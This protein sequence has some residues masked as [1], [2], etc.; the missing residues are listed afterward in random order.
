MKTYN[1]LICILL[2]VQLSA[3]IDCGNGINDFSD[4]ITVSYNETSSVSNHKIDFTAASEIPETTGGLILWLRIPNKVTPAPVVIS[5]AGEVLEN[6]SFTGGEFGDNYYYY[7][8]TKTN[9]NPNTLFPVG[10][11]V[12]IAE[13][14]FDIDLEPRD[15]E[16]VLASPFGSDAFFNGTSWTYYRSTL[17]VCSGNEDSY[18]LASNNLLPIEL[19]SFTAVPFQNKGTKIEWVTATELNGSHFEIERSDNGE[20][21]R[22]VGRIMAAG[23]SNDDQVYKYFDQEINMH[24]NE[25]VQYYRIKMVDIDGEYKY[26]GIRAVNFTRSDIEFEIKTYP[27]P[28][29]DFVILELTGL[30]EISIKRPTLSIFSNTGELVKSQVLNSDIDKIETTD[31]PL[32]LYYFIIEYRGQKYNQK[33]VLLK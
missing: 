22:Q 12:T 27:N 24:R 14:D 26:S 16:I 13:I 17:T 19:K 29:T 3:Q 15:L 10:E 11:A 6:E 4:V 25:L 1:I 7:S 21:F 30:D 18:S 28:T 5:V 20:N 8:F 32:S 31:L 23:V 9:I 2:S 33:I